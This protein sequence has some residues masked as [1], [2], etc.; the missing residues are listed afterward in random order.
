[1]QQHLPQLSGTWAWVTSF[2]DLVCLK[3]LTKTLVSLWP[4]PAIDVFIDWLD[5]LFQR[6]PRSDLF[7][8]A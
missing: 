4:F 2:A 7:S 6:H 1:M 3:A 8:G 5:W